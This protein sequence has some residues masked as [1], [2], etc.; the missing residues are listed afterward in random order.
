MYSHSMELAHTYLDK[1]R[2]LVP[3]Q[4]TRAKLIA[5]VIRDECGVQV[6]PEEITIRR[7]GVVLAC[8]PTVRCELV[9]YIP[10]VLHTLHLKHNV[11][12]SFIR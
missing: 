4:A 5:Q 12:F 6:L 8:H 3:P 2:N 7:G 9:R 10:N 11:R 1:Y